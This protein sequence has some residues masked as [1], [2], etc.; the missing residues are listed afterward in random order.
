MFWNTLLITVQILNSYIEYI[1]YIA[2]PYVQPSKDMPPTTI[3]DHWP[4]T[5]PVILMM[6]QAA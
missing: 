6:L 1:R 4:T 5:K 3:T 2:H